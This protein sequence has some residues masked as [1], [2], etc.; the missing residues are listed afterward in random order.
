MKEGP[1]FPFAF[2][3]V[4]GSRTVRCARALWVLVGLGSNPIS[5]RPG[6]VFSRGSWRFPPRSLPSPPLRVPPAA[7]R[8]PAGALPR[9]GGQ[10]RFAPRPFRQ[11]SKAMDSERGRGAG[12]CGGG[13]WRFIF[14]SWPHPFVLR[15]VRS[16]GEDGGRAASNKEQE[17]RKRLVGEVDK[18]ACESFW[19]GSAALFAVLSFS[20][21]KG[22]AC[23]RGAPR[24]RR[25]P[26]GRSS[27]VAR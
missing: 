13:G 17:K 3:F 25:S 19:P 9:E 14:L 22:R 20:V 23:A 21:P 27:F 2:S 10:K 18:R 24:S 11:A 5:P 6:P 26:A 12:D 4:S 8:L 15:C 1:A 16:P 7:E